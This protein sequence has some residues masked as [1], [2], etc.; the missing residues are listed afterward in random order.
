MH[1][2]VGSEVA[3]E[4]REKHVV[5]ELETFPLNGEYATAYCVV[6]PENVLAEMPDLD[7]LCKLH[8]AF[9]DS[10]NSGQYST[11]LDAELYLRGRFAGELDSFYDAIITRINKGAHHNG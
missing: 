3:K 10:F 1:I 11:T 9:I 2:I 8:Q 4:L 6:S 5:L 7:R